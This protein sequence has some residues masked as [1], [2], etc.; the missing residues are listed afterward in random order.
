MRKW[1]VIPVLCFYSLLCHSQDETFVFSHLKESDGLSNNVVN[2][3]IKDRQGYFWIGTYNGFNRFD[4]AN[5]YNY[6]IRK[7]NNSLLN[8]VVHSLCEDHDGKIWGAT[9]REVFRYDMHLDRF[10]NYECKSLGKPTGFN[11]I[12]CDRKGNIWATGNCSLFRYNRSKDQFEL[13]ANTAPSPDSMGGY[14]ISKNGLQEDTVKGNIWMTTPMGIV[15]YDIKTSR[16]LNHISGAGNPLFEK[17]ATTALS[18]SAS[19]HYWFYDYSNEAVVQFDPVAQKELQHIQLRGIMKSPDLATIFEDNN[20]RLWL[21]SWSYELLVVDLA[22]NNKMLHMYHRPDDNRSVSGDFYWTAYQDADGTIWLGTV[23]GLS[24]CNPE[25]NIY[26]EYRLGN[27]IPEL[28]NT[29]V[30]VAAQ[31][32]ADNSFWLVNRTGQLI[33]YIPSGEKFQV[34]QLNLAAKDKSGALPGYVSAVQFIGDQVII[35]TSTGT[36]Q[37]KKGAQQLK[38]FAML[39]AEYSDF[40]CKELVADGDSVVYLTNATIVLKWN[41]AT[42]KVENI[43][44][45]SP[46]SKQLIYGLQMA[47]PGRLWTAASGNVLAEISV[48]HLN[49]VPLIKDERKEAGTI[50]SLRADKAGNLW[51]LNKGAGI[52]RY[53]ITQKTV[54]YWNQTD[55]LPGNRMHGIIPDEAGRVWSMLYDKVSVYIPEANKFYNFEI[56]YSQSNLNYYNHL[57]KLSDGHIL[58]TIYNEIIEF[59]PERLLTMPVLHQ[60]LISLLSVG[61]RDYQVQDGSHVLLNADENTVRLKFGSLISKDIFP[62]DLEYKLVNVENNWTVASENKEALYNNLPY[63]KY[64]FR[65]RATGKNNAWQTPEAV[66]FFEIKTPF[67]RTWWFLLGIT[68]LF[69]TALYFFYRNRIRQKEKLMLLETKAQSLEKEKALVMYENLKQHL[70]PHFLFNSLTSLS[71]LIRLDQH[72][73]GNF[74]DK[75]SKVYRY[76]LK[77]RDNEVV[78]ISEELKF[79]QLYIGLQKTRFEEGLQVIINIDEEHHHRKIA[80]VTLQNLVE[81]AIKHNTADKESPLTIELFVEQDYLVVRN[82]LQK[83]KFVETSNR[84]GLANMESLYRYLSTRAMEIIENEYYFIVKIP[85]L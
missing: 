51:V 22:H 76:I 2:C 39:P 48:N 59:Y 33:H 25:K 74:L 24:R 68:V 75:M 38:P 9:N 21:S 64:E 6:T 20:R 11:N 44:S 54:S 62:Y 15:C 13:M 72:M 34:I 69:F 28:K 58:G 60:P 82:N 30:H 32:T 3:M 53:N 85:L 67:Y 8:E 77:N 35:T 23:A 55:G 78:P 16:L 4:G 73:A 27:I 1:A 66:V 19:G 10:S 63:G 84:Q 18:K 70:N 36:W 37:L 61:N 42:N 49:T 12:L 83:K 57:S 29:A 56:P 50:L 40:V 46:G 80:P 5:F 45:S 41:R 17:R 52:Y 7:G 71:S 81:N 79:V 26:K 65:V 14:M 47:A 43:Y 31:D